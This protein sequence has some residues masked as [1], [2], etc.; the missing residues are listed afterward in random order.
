MRG[1]KIYQILNF[2]KNESDN[3]NE[4]TLP[5]TKFNYQIYRKSEFRT[6]KT[7]KYAKEEA[8]EIEGTEK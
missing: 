7:E 3:K 5:I 6:W 2:R 4:I 1:N 8:K